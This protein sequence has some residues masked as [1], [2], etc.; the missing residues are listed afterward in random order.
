MALGFAS[1]PYDRFA[2]VEDEEAVG[3]RI[4]DDTFASSLY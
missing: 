1:R 3:L 2:F 4:E